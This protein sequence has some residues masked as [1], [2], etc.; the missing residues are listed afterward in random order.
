MPS[1]FSKQISCRPT[2]IF[3]LSFIF[4]IFLFF[5]SLVVFLEDALDYMRCRPRNFQR[6]LEINITARFIS[7]KKLIFYILNNFVIFDDA[8]I[9][10]HFAFLIFQSLCIVQM[11][12]QNA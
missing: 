11:M 1:T 2:N 6:F 10:Q 12:R 4:L 5:V 7:W 8:Y 9:I 3:N